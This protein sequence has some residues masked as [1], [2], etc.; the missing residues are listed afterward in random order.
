MQTETKECAGLN[1]AAHVCLAISAQMARQG[2]WHLCARSFPLLFGAGLLDHSQ[3]GWTGIRNADECSLHFPSGL[4]LSY[5]LIFIAGVSAIVEPCRKSWT[6]SGPPGPSCAALAGMQTLGGDC[7][8]AALGR[9]LG[10]WLWLREPISQ[11][12]SPW[13][14]AKAGKMDQR[15]HRLRGEGDQTSRSP[16]ATWKPNQAGKLLEGLLINWTFFFSYWKQ[17]LLLTKDLEHRDEPKDENK[18]HEWL[19]PSEI[20]ILKHVLNSSIPQ[21]F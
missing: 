7:A 6:C 9:W 17:F 13:G 10:W 1:E 21:M 18:N 15:R 2:P 12:S 4:A 11:A 16:S 14:W 20:T 8:P 3:Q 19:Q 5:Y